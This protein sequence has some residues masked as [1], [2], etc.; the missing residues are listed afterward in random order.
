MKK[1]VDFQP[2]AYIYNEFKSKFAI[3][4]QSGIAKDMISTIVFEPEYRDINALR[5]LEGYSHI[6]LIW[7]FSDNKK[8]SWSPTVRPPRLGGN[9]R[10][11]IFAT[12]SPYRPNPVGLSCVKLV[13]IVKTENY[14]TVLKV[15]GADL[16]DKTPIFD[17][18][19]Y[20]TFSDCV[21]DAKC[22][23]AD[24]TDITDIHVVFSDECLVNV[25]MHM[26]SNITQILSNNPKPSYQNDCNR[27][28]SM[29]FGDSEIKFKYEDDCILVLSVT[30]NLV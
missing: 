19:P 4:R 13:D 11:G 26:Q 5:G 9:K 21:T 8:T 29:N 16:L 22:G 7:H 27:I 17:I 1:S 28:Y 2:I 18:K 14:G 3:P 20:L 23:F 15:S 6:W 30:R 10:M 12:R 24:N 25:D